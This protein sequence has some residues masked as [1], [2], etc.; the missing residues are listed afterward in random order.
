M[1]F[2]II[3][4]SKICVKKFTAY[5]FLVRQQEREGDNLRELEPQWSIQNQ[6]RLHPALS[7]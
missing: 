6:T 1:S 7:Y 2:Q 3:N 4:I 5:N